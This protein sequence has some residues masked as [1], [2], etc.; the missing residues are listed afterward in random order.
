MG[1]FVGAPLALRVLA[2]D[3]DPFRLRRA[4]RRLQ[5][6]AAVLAG[7]SFALPEGAVAAG[8]ALPWLA[9]TGLLALAGAARLRAPDRWR[10]P[11][12][13]TT[14]GLAYAAVG[15]GWLV[16]HRLGARPLDFD[17]TIELLTAVHFHF[18]GLFLAVIAGAIGGRIAPGGVAARTYGLA[19]AGLIVGPAVVAAG[20]TASRALAIAGGA[21]LAVAVI[22]LC[23]LQLGIAARTAARRTRALLTVSSL[24]GLVAMP[25]AAFYVTAL[26]GTPS[27]ADMVLVH[28]IPNCFGL[29][30]CGLAAWSAPVSAP[31]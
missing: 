4:A 5:L 2:P 14:V 24:A 28:G 10:M 18:A 1:L 7:I 17:L 8:L 31:R 15:G 21:I 20:I 16:I 22:A 23:L 19:A 11:R 9:L 27:I 29:V 13:V 26:P 25:F 12:L 3:P 6:P 30:L